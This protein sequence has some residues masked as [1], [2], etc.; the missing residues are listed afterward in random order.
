MANSNSAGTS[1]NHTQSWRSSIQRYPASPN[2]Q[3]PTSYNTQSTYPGPGPTSNLGPSPPPNVSQPIQLIQGPVS[4]CDVYV[5][6][7]M[8]R[9]LGRVGKP[10]GTHVY[11]RNT[12]TVTITPY[13]IIDPLTPPPTPAPASTQVQTTVTSSITTQ[14]PAVGTHCPLLQPARPTLPSSTLP[15]SGISQQVVVTL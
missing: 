4:A 3:N 6:N 13:I 11:H 14:S 2:P 15:G 8:N 10:Y 5:N 1:I 9:R 7:P 12:R